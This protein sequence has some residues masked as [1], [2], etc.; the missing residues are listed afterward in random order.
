MKI[1]DVMSREVVHLSPHDAI[2]EAA[3]LMRK[4]CVSSLPVVDESGS[5]IGLLT[6][7]DLIARLRAPRRSWWQ[8]LLSD[9]AE[10]AREYQKTTGTTVAE[11]MTPAPVPA[12]P[13]LSVETAADMLSQDGIREL[14]VVADGRLVGSVSRT[15]LLQVLAATPNRTG[16]A[17]TEPELVAEMQ[18]RLAA[19]DWVSNR[20]LWVDARNGLL[21]LYGLVDS[22]EEKAALGVMARAIEGCTGVENNVFPKSQLRGR[23]GWS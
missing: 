14:P 2:L 22:E 16:V 7:R 10:S 5:I 21:S 20:G 19:E 8:T 12:S 3:R 18:K 15:E 23:G 4:S 9:R 6:E 17:R 11:V 13:D 1:A